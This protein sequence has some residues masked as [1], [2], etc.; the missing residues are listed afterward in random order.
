MTAE[1]LAQS[2]ASTR[3]VLAN[4]TPSQIEG[5]PTPCASWSVKELVD[6]IVNGTTF[7]AAVAETGTSPAEDG[8]PAFTPEGSLAA[9]D[10]GS[11]QAVRAFAAEGAMERI[12]HLPFGD[13]P[14]SLYVNIAAGDAFTHGWDLARATGQPTD[15]DPEVAIQLLDFAQAFLSDAL[16]GPEG[17][18]PFGPRQE[19]PAGASVADQLAAFMGRR[20]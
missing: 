10:A 19:A 8:Y 12:M 2:F 20:P 7:F 6:H 14:G 4:V 5:G 9:F 16:R 11:A 17:Q 13:I 3:G 18:A 15:L 1:L